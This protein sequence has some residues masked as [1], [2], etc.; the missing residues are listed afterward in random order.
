MGRPRQDS[1]IR[2][3]IRCRATPTWPRFILSSCHLATTGMAY[4]ITKT[5]LREAAAADV[6]QAAALEP[7]APRLAELRQALQDQS[8]QG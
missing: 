3:P 8:G 2:V 4:R 1:F 6:E 7:D 5:M